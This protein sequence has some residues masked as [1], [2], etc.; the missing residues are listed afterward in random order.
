MAYLNFLFIFRHS[1]YRLATPPLVY[2]E[3]MQYLD[4]KRQR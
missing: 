1:S 2:K 3:K 4:V